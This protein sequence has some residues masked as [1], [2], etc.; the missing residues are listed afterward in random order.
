MVI[1]SR[2]NFFNAELKEA[3]KPA[4]RR[5]RTTK[6]YALAVIK[7]SGTDEDRRILDVCFGKLKNREIN[8]FEFTTRIKALCGQI[9]RRR[10]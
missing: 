2:T 1:S 3:H 4:G 6:A 9:I 5:R 7:N 8:I 10:S